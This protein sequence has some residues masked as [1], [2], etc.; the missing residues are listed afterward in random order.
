MST[1][2]VRTLA[3]IST[4]VNVLHLHASLML[5]SAA[6]IWHL[7]SF[8][9]YHTDST[10]L[11]LEALIQSSSASYATPGSTASRLTLL[12]TVLGLQLNAVLQALDDLPQYHS[13]SHGYRCQLKV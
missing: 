4:V 7:H 6:F 10:L 5:Q 13:S 8:I 12:T 9:Q 11:D 2:A 3:K 1:V